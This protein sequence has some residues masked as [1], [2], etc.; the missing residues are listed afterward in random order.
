MSSL[1]A[2][3][4]AVSSVDM[5]G[6]CEARTIGIVPSRRSRPGNVRES[7]KSSQPWCRRLAC[8]TY[9]RAACTTAGC[10]GLAGSWE[11][12]LGLLLDKRLVAALGGAGLGLG[13][14]DL[15]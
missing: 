13:Q 14:D 8:K 11:A 6:P 9:R 7:G 5:C 1:T 10:F 3:K 12:G 4:R 2:A 15:R